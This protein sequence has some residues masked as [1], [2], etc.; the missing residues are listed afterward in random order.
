MATKKKNGKKS[1]KVTV[2][3][4]RKEMARPVEASSVRRQGL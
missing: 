1:A 4:V 2:S 3:E